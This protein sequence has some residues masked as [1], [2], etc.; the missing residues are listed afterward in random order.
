MSNLDKNKIDE[1]KTKISREPKNAKLYSELADQYRQAGKISEAIE[2]YN[3]AIS[4]ESNNPDYYL[5]RALTFR[6]NN[7][8][9]EA[10]EDI[11][12][13]IDCSPFDLDLYIYLIDLL[14]ESNST[15]S[16]I[17]Y[18]KK[19]LLDFPNDIR[20]LNL[21]ENAYY[22]KG[23]LTKS[24]YYHNQ[25]ITTIK[26]QY[27]DIH[28]A[29]EDL[30][31]LL[32]RSFELKNY[33]GALNYS[34]TYL[35]IF[36][37]P[38]GECELTNKIFEIIKYFED[39]NKFDQAL[40]AC[41]KI[42]ETD[43]PY[44]YETGLLDKY[45][46]ILSKKVA[47]EKEHEKE[48][49]VNEER[50]KIIANL[51]HSIKNM[52][53][54]VI[55]PL[56]NLKQEKI[57]Q[58]QVIENALRGANL[59]REIVNAINLSSKG[60]IDDFYYDAQQ[61]DKSDSLSIKEIIIESLKYSVGNM[62]DGKYFSTFMR[63]YFPTKPIFLD[64]KNDWV[65]ISQTNDM[66]KLTAFLKKYFFE[67]ELHLTDEEQFKIGN[68]KGSAIKL[69]ILFQELIFNAV[70]YSAFVDR[71]DRF[72]IITIKNTANTISIKVQNKFLSKE[73]SKTTGIGHVVIENFSKLL[74]TQPVIKKEKETYTVELIFENIWR[75]KV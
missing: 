6:K 44:F 9:K 71:T 40:D 58:P 28:N 63:K 65:K 34:L 36:G 69:L 55:D 60:S 38:I 74:N 21:I 47:Y 13:A 26:N 70:K 59:I 20:L 30:K 19:C 33:E 73:K 75:A 42:Q 61:N 67:L 5:F 23:N 35:Q 45:R 16:A 1:I 25:V 15:T 29:G 39:N 57:A 3:N 24:S 32:N 7:R 49:A 11:K 18:L 41:K 50:N 72:I 27:S 8:T 43:P 12:R 53:S 31:N 2:S 52:I 14:L 54:T 22:K 4:L 46:I 37:G 17:E 64:A 68:Q 56:E 51:S 66:Q 62:F 48:V 10:I